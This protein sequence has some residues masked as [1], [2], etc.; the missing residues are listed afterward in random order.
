MSRPFQFFPPVFSPMKNLIRIVTFS[1]WAVGAFGQS[2]S[3]VRSPS[4]MRLVVADQKAPNLSV[5][6]PGATEEDKSIEVI[7]PEHVT[8][9]LHGSTEA[10]HV[11]LSSSSLGNRPSWHQTGSSLEYEMDLKG[12]IHFLARAVLQDDGVLFHYEFTNRSQ[13]AYDMIYAPTD[14]RLTGIFHD[15]RLE[16]TYVHHKQGFDLLASETPGRLRM[17]LNQWLPSRYLASYTWPV[18]QQRVEHRDDGITYYNKSQPV[19]EPMVA[20]LSTDRKWVVASF[21]RTTGNVWSNPELTCQHV[22]PETALPAGAKA[23]MEVKLLVFRGTLDDALQ[24]VIAQ[25]NTLN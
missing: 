23:T 17:P 15:V 6:L 3:P 25:R 13:K 16:R 11:Y 4:G 21:T 12:G 24:K 1:L 22:D 2:L 8:A 14:P 10:E 9:R 19:D 18:P 7:F 5:I 20:T